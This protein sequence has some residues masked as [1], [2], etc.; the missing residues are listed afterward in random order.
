MDDCNGDLPLSFDSLSVPRQVQ[1]GITILCL[2][3]SLQAYSIPLP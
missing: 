1:G 2:Y 3:P